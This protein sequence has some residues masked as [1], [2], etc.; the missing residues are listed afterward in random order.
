MC[1]NHHIKLCR[2]PLSVEN[3]DEQVGDKNIN[4]VNNVYENKTQAE[5]ESFLDATCFSS[6]KLT[7]VEDVKNGNFA[8]LPG[9]TV[10]FVSYHLPNSEANIF[11]HLDQTQ[12]TPDHLQC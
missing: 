2:F 11:G 6:I 4:V 8:T 5:L 12:K 10:E 9:L 7:L 1:I 3:E